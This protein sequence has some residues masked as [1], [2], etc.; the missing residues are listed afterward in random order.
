MEIIKDGNTILKLNQERAVKT[1]AEI[2][3][4]LDDIVIGARNAIIR[5]R[6]EREEDMSCG[7]R[8]ECDKA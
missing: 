1:Q 5:A 3:A 6:L 4:I 7:I 8:K 2:D